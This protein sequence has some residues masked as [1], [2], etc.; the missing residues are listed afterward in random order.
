[1]YAQYTFCD[2]ILLVQIYYYRY[3]HRHG[4]VLQRSEL[5][6]LLPSD[7]SDEPEKPQWRKVLSGRPAQYFYATM[8]VLMTG[9]AS[10]YMGPNHKDQPESGQDVPLEWKSQVLGWTSAVLYSEYLIYN[11]GFPTLTAIRCKLDPEF[12]KSVSP[13]ARQPLSANVICFSKERPDQMRWSFF[14]TVRVRSWWQSNLCAFD[15]RGFHVVALRRGKR[16]LVS[17]SVCL[18]W[19]TRVRVL[20]TSLDPSGSALTMFLDFFVSWIVIL[21]LAILTCCRY[22]GN[23]TITARSRMLFPRK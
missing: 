13:H 16:R 12:R 14:G 17:G 15:S 6:P 23:S 4:L 19:A 20:T 1:M 11:L 9:L 18:G 5:T 2:I 7:A 3:K 8:F 22:S 10:W 21:H